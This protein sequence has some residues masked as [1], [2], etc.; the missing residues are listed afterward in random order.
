MKDTGDIIAY[1]PIDDPSPMNC[2]LNAFFI[3]LNSVALFPH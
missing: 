2:G 1:F 3:L